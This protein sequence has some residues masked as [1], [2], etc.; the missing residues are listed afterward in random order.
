M[1]EIEKAYNKIKETI[2]S[3][4]V[5]KIGLKVI[6]VGA[7]I[8]LAYY[9]ISSLTKSANGIILIATIISKTVL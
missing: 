9:L 1:N 6:L 2:A 3:N 7:G 8:Y 4:R 5:Y